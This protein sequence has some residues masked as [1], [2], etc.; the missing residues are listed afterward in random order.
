MK[1]KDPIISHLAEQNILDEDTLSNLLDQQAETGRS[2]ISLLKSKKLISEEQLTKLIAAAN[3]IEFVKLSPDMVDS[4]MAHQLSYEMVNR[5]NVIPVR[6]NE[7][8]T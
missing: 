5:H 8:A 4:M 2:L 1:T 7:F 6:G 3:D